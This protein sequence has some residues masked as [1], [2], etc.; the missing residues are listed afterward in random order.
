MGW[1][2]KIFLASCFRQ[3]S[4][5]WPFTVPPLNDQNSP[6]VW[7]YNSE[8][9]RPKV[10]LVKIGRFGG[11]PKMTRF[12]PKMTKKWVKT[13]KIENRRHS[14]CDPWGA[15]KPHMKRFLSFSASFAKLELWQIL[16]YLRPPPYSKIYQ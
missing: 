3:I 14:K 2:Q 9:C 8:S 13:Q 16:P 11:T 7:G 12:D 10:D 6:E 1:S 4:R 15:Q 5:F